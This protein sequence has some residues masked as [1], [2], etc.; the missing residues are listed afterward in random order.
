MLGFKVPH[1]WRHGGIGLNFFAIP[2]NFR[3][4]H[5]KVGVGG[6]APVSLVCL[7]TLLPK[8]GEKV[9]WKLYYSVLPAWHDCIRTHSILTNSGTLWPTVWILNHATH[10][11]RA[12]AV[13]IELCVCGQ[14]LS[15]SVGFHC[16]P[17][18]SPTDNEQSSITT[19]Y[20]SFHRPFSFL[21]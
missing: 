16:M 9:Q 21:G 7:R 1:A 5:A 8:E 6:H 4:Y 14:L 18:L 19:G 12:P 20:H 3:P 10:T 15:C 17:T 13:E 11:T 2:V